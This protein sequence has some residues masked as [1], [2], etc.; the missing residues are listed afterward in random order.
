MKRESE[1][2][3]SEQNEIECIIEPFFSPALFI[4]LFTRAKN[5]YEM[6]VFFHTHSHSHINSAPFLYNTT[7]THAYTT[8]FTYIDFKYGR[9]VGKRYYFLFN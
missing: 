3:Q 4:R 1:K 2:K 5:S 7:L 8:T 9:W 6:L